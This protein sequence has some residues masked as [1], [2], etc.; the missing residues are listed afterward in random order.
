MMSDMR[1]RV[2]ATDDS[3]DF[4]IESNDV[5]SL[6]KR[7]N[8]IKAVVPDRICGKLLR[9]CASQLSCVFTTLFSWSLR[10]CT[11]P[12]IWKTSTICPV[13]K[14]RSPSELNDY[15]PAALTSVVMKCFER[16]VLQRLLTQTRHLLDPHQ[17]AYKQNRST[18]DALTLTLLNNVYPHLEKSESFVRILFVD[19]SS[20][21]NTVGLNI[22]LF[23][24]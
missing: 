24:T 21:F 12:S 1:K 16:I 14:S 22:V 9:L 15:R 6:F 13:P 20:A 4:Q 2:E 5:E 8:T 23:R 3:V 17:F 11:V 18:D 19:F 10:D 7:L